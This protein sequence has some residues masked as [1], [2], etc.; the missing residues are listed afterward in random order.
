M[1]LLANFAAWAFP[2]GLLTEIIM[3]PTSQYDPER[4]MPDLTGKVA[5]V[6]GAN[7]GIG[8]ET[9]KQLVQHNARVYVAA[10][11]EEKALAAV[12][13]LN[14]FAR[15]KESEGEARWVRLDLGDLDSV[16]RAAEEFKGREKQLDLLFCN[17]GVMACP[18]D[19]L[20]TQGYDLQWGTNVIGHYLLCTLLLPSLRASF[21][22]TGTKPRIIHTTSNGHRFAPSSSSS[23]P[24][25]DFRTTSGGA[26]RDAVVHHWAAVGYTWT[27]YGQSKIGNIMVSNLLQQQYGDEVVSMSVHPGAI[28]SELQR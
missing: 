17:A 16:K 3:P 23:T 19:L 25:L 2:D 18:V 6:T 28:K 21:L 26:A 7:T 11:S 24:G 9:A 1:G 10:R 15:E 22:S 4:D 13:K 27:L 5:L 8:F 20:T 12:E 14:A